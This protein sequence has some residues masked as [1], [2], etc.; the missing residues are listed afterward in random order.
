VLWD[1]KTPAGQ[2]AA[3]GVYFYTLKA[4]GTDG[5]N[6]DQKGTITLMR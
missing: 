5:E 1:G 4:I 3:E 2:D 6:Y